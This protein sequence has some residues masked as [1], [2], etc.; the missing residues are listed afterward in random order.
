MKKFKP[1]S[2]DNPGGGTRPLNVTNAPP[3]PAARFRRSPYFLTG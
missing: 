1:N 3:I 2:E